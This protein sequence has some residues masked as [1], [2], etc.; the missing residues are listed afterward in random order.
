ML[1]KDAIWSN[2]LRKAFKRVF[3][4]HTVTS[5]ENDIEQA[6]VEEAKK[7]D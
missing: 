4:L 1:E 5:I 6:M 3:N 2:E 7:H